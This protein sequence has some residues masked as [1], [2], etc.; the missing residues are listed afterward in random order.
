MPTSDPASNRLWLDCLATLPSVANNIVS[1]SFGDDYDDDYK[2]ARTILWDCG[3][4]V[5]ASYVITDKVGLPGRMSTVQL[6]EIHE[7]HGWD[8]AAHVS[9][10]LT[11][12]DEAGVRRELGTI[13]PFLLEYG[14]P[15]SAAHFTLSIGRCN[16]LMLRTSQNY[17]TSVCITE[18][19][20]ET[21][22]PGDPF[23][24]C[25]FYCGSYTTESQVKKA[26]AHC[27]EYRCWA[28]MVS[29]HIDE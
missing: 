12:L 27:W 28:H 29:H 19:T 18:N 26:L 5:A 20:P 25:A 1:I 3:I 16:D 10:D 15:E 24:L 8:I 13:R 17:F 4:G 22:T 14:Y 9:T 7:R 2:T 21:L 6:A 23:W 11:T